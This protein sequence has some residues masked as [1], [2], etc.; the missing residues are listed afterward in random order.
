ME[1]YNPITFIELVPNDSD[2]Y[3]EETFENL[4]PW[5]N[6]QTLKIRCLPENVDN[7]S[8]PITSKSGPYY[9]Y[10]YEFN[11]LGPTQDQRK[12]INSFEA[13][14]C[15]VIIYYAD[16]TKSYFGNNTEPVTCV[17]TPIN[18]KL[19]KNSEGLRIKLSCNSTKW[20]ENH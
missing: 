16:E 10:N 19:Y 9:Q 7:K 12:Q 2:Y 4:E 17:A 1:N 3:I 14:K 11:F 13:N 20:P 5:S 6:G 15:L 8:K 18:T